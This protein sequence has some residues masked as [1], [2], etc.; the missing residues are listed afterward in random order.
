KA[1]WSTALN[2]NLPTGGNITLQAADA[3]DE[4]HDITLG[5]VLSGNGGFTKTGGGRLTLSGAS[6][7]GG[8]VAINGGVLDLTGSLGPGGDVA[9][10][11]GGMLTGTGTAD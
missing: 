8:A 3:A 5:G 6:T 11:N 7:F 10:N 2:A 4:P 1:D 9:V